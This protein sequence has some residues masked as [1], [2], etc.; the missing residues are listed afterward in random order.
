MHPPAL[1]LDNLFLVLGPE[2]TGTTF[3][4]DMIAE[5]PNIS[6]LNDDL[7]SESP[8]FKKGID[9]FTFGNATIKEK[10]RGFLHV[11]SA[12][13]SIN[14]NELTLAAGCKMNFQ[15]PYQIQRFYNI[16]V[17]FL[18]G[19]KIIIVTRKDLIAQYASFIRMHLTGITHSTHSI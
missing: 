9:I 8:F 4:R 16:L 19:V 7:N 14:S 10:E 1:N 18:P 2:R 17:N 12:L 6:I 15:Y 3:I 5:N 13:A 11:I